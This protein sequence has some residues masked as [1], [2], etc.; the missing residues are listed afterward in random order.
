V[1]SSDE[2]IALHL[3]GLSNKEIAART[4]RTR[5]AVIGRI[6]RHT[7]RTHP[8]APRKGLP[9]DATIRKVLAENQGVIRYTAK[10][11]GVSQQR[12]TSAGYR[13][14]RKAKNRATDP[15][16]REVVD[17][18]F[19]SPV[20]KYMIAEGAGIG[21]NTIY[22]WSSG[23]HTG[24]PFLLACVRDYLTKNTPGY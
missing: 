20:P 16:T 8:A 24:R 10:A 7:Q 2:V 13:N 12:L 5:N 21:L 18:I 4:G 17:M 1:H 15:A 19:E 22:G 14:P 23:N 6:W 3:Q 9:D 11:L